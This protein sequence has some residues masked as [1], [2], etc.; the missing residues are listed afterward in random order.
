MTEGTEHYI[1]HEDMD[2]VRIYKTVHVG[3]I[4]KT[5][6]IIKTGTSASL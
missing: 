4:I 5:G 1:N 6:K 2:C 3:E